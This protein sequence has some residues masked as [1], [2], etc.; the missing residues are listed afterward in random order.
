MKQTKFNY[1]MSKLKEIESMLGQGSAGSEQQAINSALIVNNF[2]MVKSLCYM[3]I[4]SQLEQEKRDT[5]HT[6]EQAEKDKIK[7]DSSD[8]NNKEI[9]LSAE[10]LLRHCLISDKENS[11]IY[12]LIAIIHYELESYESSLKYIRE[13]LEYS[14]DHMIK[15]YF[16]KANS[17]ALMGRYD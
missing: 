3:N 13:A 2:N 7:V 11:L 6:A 8:D 5:V 16:A 9:L 15:H 14:D 17:K 10:E 1:A 12:Y 4:Y